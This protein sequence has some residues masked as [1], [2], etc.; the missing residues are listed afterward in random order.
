MRHTTPAGGSRVTVH[1]V[2]ATCLMSCLGVA[3]ASEEQTNLREVLVTAE[4]RPENAQDVPIA[5]TAM[6][7]G[8]LEKRNVSNVEGVF[9]AVPSITFVPYVNSSDTFFLYMR[10]L[11]F[12]DPGQISADG[13]VGI[14]QDGF[15]IARPQGLA[16]DLQDLARV[17]VLRGPQGTLYGRNTV[18]G[19]V[20]LVSREPT[21]EFGLREDLEFGSRHHVRTFTAINLPRVASLSLKFTLLKSSTEGFITDPGE[22]HNFG[23]T[24]ESGGRLQLRWDAAPKVRADYFLELSYLDSTP[25]YVVNTQFSGAP[26]YGGVPYLTPTVRPDSA[27]RPVHL[28]LSKTRV[29]NQGLTLTWSPDDRLT[30][31]SL[32]GYRELNASAFQNFD[33]SD[34]FPDFQ[35]KNYVHQRQLSEEL[36]ATGGLESHTFSYVLGAYLFYERGSNWGSSRSLLPFAFP[37]EHDSATAHS[38]ALYGQATWSPLRPVDLTAGLRYTHDRKSGQRTEDTAPAAPIAEATRVAYS[39]VTPGFTISYHWTE[40]LSTYARIQKGYKSGAP[41]FLAPVGRFNIAYGPEHLT[42][43]EVGLKSTWIDNKLRVNATAFDTRYRDEQKAIQ[44]APYVFAYDA[45][46]IGRQTIRGIELDAAAQVLSRIQLS[47]SYAFLDARIEQLPAP[48]STIFD[49]AVNPFSPYHVGENVKDLF[50]AGGGYAPRHSYDV[51]AEYIVARLSASTLS[52]H[53]DFRHQGDRHGAGTAL[54]GWQFATAPA[55]GVLNGNVAWDMRLAN[56]AEARVYGWARNL[57]NEDKPLWVSGA[58]SGVVPISAAP[59]G[60]IGST[61]ASWMEPRTFGISVRLQM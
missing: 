33:E 4:K 53:A 47:A 48:A 37:S 57:L 10:G 6:T 19:A 25:Q 26:I 2:I 17:E 8:D 50:A 18:G 28:P 35:T 11:G 23:E 5:L 29:S 3:Q 34:G 56:G 24:G 20:N 27:Y 9:A 12:V 15:Y 1:L 60:Y 55:F 61:Y 51:S 7:A 31:K 40:N 42:S 41:N 45:F 46:N 58:G 13:A 32:T 21:G 43:Y 49:P 52:V 39:E 44:V 16:L 54:A 14:Y 36:Q 59:A 22:P 30:L 38:E